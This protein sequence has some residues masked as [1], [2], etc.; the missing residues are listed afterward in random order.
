MFKGVKLTMGI[1]AAAFSASVMFAAAASPAEARNAAQVHTATLASPFAERTR[2]IAGRAVWY[3]E[4]DSCTAS[5]ERPITVRACRLLAREVG[6]I[7]AFTGAE[8]ALTAEQIAS[9]N[10]A[11]RPRG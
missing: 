7:A 11:A 3:C 8:A 5:V 6:E 2:I 10:T 4:G 1:L 9:C